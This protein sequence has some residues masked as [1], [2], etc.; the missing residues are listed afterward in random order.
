MTGEKGG[1]GHVS[2]WSFRETGWPCGCFSRGSA[3]DPTS[4][5]KMSPWTF[6]LYLLLEFLLSS[7]QGLSL[8]PLG[9]QLV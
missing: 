3:G 7:R 5:A 8:L 1:S 6:S 4:T 2:A 9:S